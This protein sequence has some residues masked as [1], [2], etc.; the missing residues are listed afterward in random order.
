[1]KPILKKTLLYSFF[2]GLSLS[3]L[4]VISL[5]VLYLVITP[6]LPSVDTLKDIR[7]QV[8]LRVYT[9]Q[10][11]LIAE[12]GEV[13]RQ[14]L[15][16]NEF[17]TLL[18]QSIL[19]AE[20]DRFFIHPGVDYKG[21][22][23]AVFKVLT[24]GERSQGGST[25]TMQVARNFFLS[26]EKTYTRKLNEIFLALKIEK[27]LTK[28]EILALYLNKIYLGKRA[29][30]YAAA[31]QVY[32]GQTLKEL[33]LAQIAM[34]AGLPKAPSR[35]NPVANPERATQRRNHIL[36]RMFYDLD[37]I[38][39]PEYQAAVAEVDDSK[40][41]GQS[42][43]VQARY[44][45]EM[46]RNEMVERFGPETYVDGYSVYT[47]IDGRLQQ[48]ANSALRS[49]LLAYDRRHGYR[50]IEAH[51]EDISRYTTA[52][53]EN[54]TAV[55][56]N[57]DRD[58]FEM[59]EDVL[60]DYSDVGKMQAAVVVAVYEQEVYARTKDGNIAYLSWEQLEWARRFIDDDTRGPAPKLASDILAEGDIIYTYPAKKGCSWL[61]KNPTVAG[62]MV[63]LA[64]GDGAIE[65]L[66][67]GFNYYQS[68]FNRVVQAK[69][70]PGSSFKPFIYTAA[71]DKGF[72]A[73]TVIN[74]A[75]VVF[76]APGLEDT[77]RPEN[78][79]GRF[80]GPTRLRQALIKS[81]NLVSIR[82]LR[83]IGIGYSA[84]YLK[85]FGFSKDA[86]P[87]DLS[88]AL[89][90][91]TITPLELAQAYASFANGG[92]RV[93]PYFIDYIIGP[94]RDL[95]S[96]SSPDTVCLECEDLEQTDLETDDVTT[97][98]ALSDDILNN[99]NNE[100]DPEIE[101]DIDP[102]SDNQAIAET[103]ANNNGIKIADLS[104]EQADIT[105]PDSSV[106]AALAEFDY[107]D[108]STEDINEGPHQIVLAKRIISPQVSFL[109]NTMLRDVVRFGTGR[110]ARV[111]GRKD[112]SGKTGTTNDQ[113]DAWF[114]GFNGNV[115]TISWVGFDNP[116]PL[117]N[118]ET[119]ARAALPMW[120]DYMRQSL[121][122]KAETPLEQ[123]S[124]L[125]S[126]RIDA[127]TGLP[128]TIN[129]EKTL[130]EFFRESHAPRTDNV[131]QQNQKSNNSNTG[132]PSNITEEIF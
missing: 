97:V 89:G 57:D 112:L 19:A 8:P 53:D 25:I 121:R 77:W 11:D 75:P 33:N 83:D 32:Y 123:P 100:S 68:K 54:S 38:Q 58:M 90:S 49:A 119:G 87:R 51:S 39:E 10:G 15:Q 56:S 48:A 107:S 22:L 124:G 125:V 55:E 18:I 45:A 74:D 128:S 34:L 59:W 131:N 85:R 28:K 50:G 106:E 132:Q 46:V 81:R 130:F 109:M 67:G 88:L 96:R 64:S 63:S 43:D 31:A 84:R 41:H 120:I 117:G 24:T 104:Q 113:Q 116:K 26:R 99:S 23:R 60:S 103:E 2:T 5:F 79:S 70:Q 114:S 111:I 102:K 40:V 35:Y 129:S 126:I 76:E 3:I 9:K 80:Y 7:L 62:A 65:S 71:L 6:K 17:P 94:N 105:D 69:R 92:F 93:K 16:Y 52:V 110:R 13:K 98:I 118:R 95:V 29:Y 1:M 122:G 44:V 115:V 47:T 72:T 30:G 127:K 12:F 78:Y 73:A 14:P 82:L 66:V 37:F 101:T 42:I 61:A 108:L 20:D 86:L 21:I 27:E 91:G 4:G 36:R